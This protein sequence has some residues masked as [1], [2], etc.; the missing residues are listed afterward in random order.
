MVKE[1]NFNPTAATL[2]SIV[3]AI[4][5]WNICLGL[6]QINQQKDGTYCMRT[7]VFMSSIRIVCSTSE[8][9]LEDFKRYKNAPFGRVQL[10]LL[11]LYDNSISTEDFVYQNY[12]QP[13][14]WI[15]RYGFFQEDV[16][17]PGT[18]TVCPGCLDE[19]ADSQPNY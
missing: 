9:E 5:L 12:M 8:K 14:M 3:M 19:D 13:H 6:D 10:F 7:Q 15:K 1:A 16:E 17:Q 4:L 2:L 18:S 11:S